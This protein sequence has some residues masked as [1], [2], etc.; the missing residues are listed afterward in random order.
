MEIVVYGLA[1]AGGL[2]LLVVA[3]AVIPG[4]L[5]PQEPGHVDPDLLIEMPPLAAASSEYDRGRRA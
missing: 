3:G 2:A 1:A 5:Q 4:T